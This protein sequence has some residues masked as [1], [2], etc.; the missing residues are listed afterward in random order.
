ME[1]NIIRNR[2]WWWIGFSRL[3]VRGGSCDQ[4]TGASGSRKWD[5][6]DPL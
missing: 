6:L 3:R 4:S 2:M 5:V 1:V